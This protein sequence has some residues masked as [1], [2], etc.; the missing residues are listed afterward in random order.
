MKLLTTKK[1]LLLSFKKLNIK[2]EIALQKLQL[3]ST[4]LDSATDKDVVSQ[5]EKK[6][7]NSCDKIIAM[8]ESDFKHILPDFIKVEQELHALN[9]DS[10]GGTTTTDFSAL[11]PE[12][13][14]WQ[15]TISGLQDKCSAKLQQIIASEEAAREEKEREE[16]QKEL[17]PIDTKNLSAQF[18]QIVSEL[19]SIFN[20]KGE[21][22][23]SSTSSSV[24]P[25]EKSEAI[26]NQLAQVDEQ[27]DHIVQLKTLIQNNRKKIQAQI[28]DIEDPQLKTAIVSVINKKS[29]N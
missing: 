12:Y 7:P 29:K 4:K 18:D 22:I 24:S 23:E 5:L 21:L 20:S 17:D 19:S 26:D 27:I 25:S 6:L 1:D 11:S 10:A 28:V 9:S 15:E 2:I 16:E 8:L 13:K 3:I 14:Q